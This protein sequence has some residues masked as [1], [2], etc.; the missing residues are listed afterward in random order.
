MEKFQALT[1][2]KDHDEVITQLTSFPKSFLP[3]ED[4]LIDVQYSGVN[5][6]DFLATQLNGGVVNTYPMIPGID[7]AGTV[8]ASHVPEFTVGQ[9]VLATSFAIGVSHYGGFS[10]LAS[11]KKEWV[12]PLPE[13]LSLKESMLLGTAGLTAALSIMALEK[14]GMTP[15]SRVLIT[16]AT[17]GVASIARLILE[18]LG[19]TH[20]TLMSQKTFG[21]EKFATVTTKDFLAQKPKVLSKQN[22]DYVIDSVGGEVLSRVIPEVAYDGAI[23]AFGNASGFKVATTVF[24]FILRGITLLGI[25]SVNTRTKRRQEAWQNLATRYKINFSNL[26]HDTVSLAELPA[27]FTQ[28]KLGQHRGRTLVDLRK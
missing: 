21:H 16:G 1:V 8:V 12:I 19:Y 23:A 15:N 18:K 27:V 4:V 9:K 22:Y 13:N 3:V 28:F 24:P 25:D 26:T 10:Q 2:E 7:L 6:K 20:L 17:G 14:H 11:L 5:F